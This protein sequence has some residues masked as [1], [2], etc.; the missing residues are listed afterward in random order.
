MR[1]KR[2]LAPLLLCLAIARA[3]SQDLSVPDTA[4]TDTP[5]LERA[6]PDLAQQALERLPPTDPLTRLEYQFR[7][8]L[9]AGQYTQATATLDQLQKARPAPTETQRVDPLLRQELFARSKVLEGSE[10]LSYAE[11]FTR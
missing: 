5:A 10:K 7:L 9:A 3:W 8:Q 4:I 1:T 2:S 6:I 11:A